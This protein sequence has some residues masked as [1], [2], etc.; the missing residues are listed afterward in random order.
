MLKLSK[1]KQANFE[2][3]EIVSRIL[4]E[5]PISKGARHLHDVYLKPKIRPYTVK[6]TIKTSSMPSEVSFE[7]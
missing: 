6:Q 3:F 4:E 7:S 5:G 1:L 2:S